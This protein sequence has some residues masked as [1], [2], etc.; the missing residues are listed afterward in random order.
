[1]AAEIAVG[2]ASRHTLLLTDFDGT[3]AELALAPDAAALSGYVRGELDLIATMP[4]LTLGVVSGRRRA[5]VHARVGPSPQYVAGLHGLEIVGPHGAFH[6]DALDH[7][8]P[9]VRKLAADAERQLAWCPGYLIE[10]KTYALTCH[11]R[12]TP[13]ELADR[14]LEEFEAL[15]EPYLEAGVLRVLTGAKAVELLPAVDWHKG[16]AVDWIRHDVSGRVGQPITVIYLGDDRTDEDAF[17]SLPDDDVAIAVGERPH[18][19]LIDYRLA[20]PASVG[21]FFAALRRERER[22]R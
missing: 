14:A 7:V 21:R 10:N 2:L 5:D 6:H 9:I 17:S 3:L 4:H 11:V 13:P 16:R 20:G 18:T 1:V 19:H 15:A 12:R 8:A 22:G